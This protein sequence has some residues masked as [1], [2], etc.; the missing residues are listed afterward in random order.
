M[1][2][3]PELINRLVGLKSL[4]D[5]GDTELAAMA[6]SRLE[7]ERGQP[8]VGS[9]LDALADHRYA[10]A[11]GL[12][13]RLLT[14]GTRLAQWTDPE[15][16]LLAEELKR[17]TAE[18]ADLETEQAELEHLVARF[19]AAHNEA[20]GQR[21]SQL[22]KLR[23]RLLEREL[24]RQPEAQAAFDQARREFEEFEQEQEIQK[25][26][27]A[28]TKWELSDEEEAELKRLF[29]SASKLCHPDLVAPEHHD[30]AAQMFR[31]LRRAYDEGD[32]VRVRQLAQRTQ[33]GLFD[34]KDEAT[35]N[36]ERKKV[37]LRAKIAGIREA[38]ER[39]RAHVREIKHSSTY[40]TMMENE[41]WAAMFVTQAQVLDQ[42]IE[43]LAMK[44]EEM[45][46]AWA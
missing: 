10:D 31:E 42:E 13:E 7:S 45:Q 30:A 46:D 32:L 11:A 15:L 8:E 36:D 27:D 16:A 43:A 4:L 22:L 24:K 2:L 1:N 12:I 9:I 25:E 29:R 14:D 17:V 41:D 44:L 21:I 40:Q 34:A 37:Q 38:L 20:L 18:L 26:T 19:Q 23:M 28:R 5:L 35:Y 6:A 33:A 39:A 3:S